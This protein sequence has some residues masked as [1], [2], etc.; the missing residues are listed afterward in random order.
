MTVRLSLLISVSALLLAA[1]STIP[2]DLNTDENCKRCLSAQDMA[3]IR[4]ILMTRPGIKKP[5]WGI[6][7][8]DRDHVITKSGGDGREDSLS[9]VTTLVRKNGRWQI[10]KVRQQYFEKVIITG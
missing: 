4:A 5:L 6:T 1:C 3:E 10:I 8:D 2:L 9:S 7:C